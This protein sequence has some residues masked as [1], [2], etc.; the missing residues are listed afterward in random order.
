[1]EISG[2]NPSTQLKCIPA[3]RA[4]IKKGACSTA[5]L[6]RFLSVAEIVRL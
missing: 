5:W 4:S 1:L 6:A 3:E 2:Q